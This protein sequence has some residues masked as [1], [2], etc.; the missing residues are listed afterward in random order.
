MGIIVFVFDVFKGFA[1]VGLGYVF[2]GSTGAMTAFGAVVLG[3]CFPAVWGFKGGKGVAASFGAALALN[4][5]SALAAFL[6]A[7]LLFILT[8]RV[9]VASLGAALSYPVLVWFC[10]HEY[11]YFSVGAALFLIMMHA[12]NIRRIAKGEEKK[13]TIG[14]KDKAD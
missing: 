3:H 7:G 11:F 12:A 1:S 6:V 9:S 2:G 13:L 4:W 8:R 5:V 14:G 10:G